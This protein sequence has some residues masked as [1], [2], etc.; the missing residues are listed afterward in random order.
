MVIPR[1][2]FGATAPAPVTSHPV[3][4]QAAPHA[5]HGAYSPQKVADAWQN[6]FDA[7]GKQDLDKIMLDYD[8][9]SVC[10]V[11]N[12]TDGVKKEYKGQAEIRA[13]FAELFATLPDLATLDAPVVDVDEAGEQVFL[14]WMCPG[15]GYQ[16]ATD[17][18]FFKRK[19]CGL[20]GHKFVISRQNIVVTKVC[21]AARMSSGYG[22]GCSQP[23]AAKF[24]RASSDH[25]LGAV[26]DD[27]PSTDLHTFIEGLPKCELHVHIEGTL[28]PETMLLLAQGTI[29][30][31]GETNA[32]TVARI[33]KERENFAD[34][35]DFL[36][37]YNGASAML[38]KHADFYYLMKQYIIRCKANNVR[39]AEIFFDP[40]SHLQRG[41]TFDTVISGLHDAL[42]AE[43]AVG[44]P[45]G[46]EFADRPFSG[47]LI[48]CFLRDWKVSTDDDRKPA[49]PSFT[50]L[51]SATEALEAAKPFVDKIIAVGMDNAEVFGEP[52]LFQPVFEAAKAAGIAH[53]VCHAGEEG[54]PKP[55]VSDAL[56]LLKVERLDHGVQT[57]KDPE[58]AARV[59]K[60][61]IALTVCPC[62]NDRLKVFDHYFDGRRDVVRMLMDAGLKVTLNSDDPAY[63]GGFMNVNFLKTAEDSN[64]SK[65]E[66]LEFSR[67]AFEATFAP[68]SEKQAW[69]EELLAY[70]KAQGVN[71]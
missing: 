31:E 65:A 8:A 29:Q 37:M 41:V 64:C 20:F 34:L 61:G 7:F 46:C 67:N 36:R 63:F 25:A 2:V 28:E 56:D 16:T 39:Y 68:A 60:E 43:G 59:A 21:V 44:K 17:S 49:D 5:S 18:F 48:M 26:T 71:L 4:A 42:Q 10:R 22:S 50:G 51:P 1:P 9:E 52:K 38:N 62:S 54:T 12:N 27:T 45:D 11:Y 19:H 58:L 35:Q 69:I 14:V 3:H 15:C 24:W 32:Q 57:I 33:T 66:L 30:K 55:F 47:R 40:Q 13:M 6:H 23:T 70:G 53:A